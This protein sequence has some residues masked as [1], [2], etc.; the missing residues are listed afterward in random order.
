LS[1]VQTPKATLDLSFDGMRMR[2]AADHFR[3]L[4]VPDLC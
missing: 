3:V 4:S 2:R 1:V